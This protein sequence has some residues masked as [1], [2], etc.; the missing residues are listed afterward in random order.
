[1]HFRY[2]EWDERFR[3]NKGKD[4]FNQ[5]FDIFQQLLN[6]SSG[7]AE[8]ALQWLTELD[9]M[10]NLTKDMDD[11]D[12]GDFI[13]ELE[14][15]GYIENG[16]DDEGGSTIY[17]TRKTEKSLRQQALEDIFRDLNKGTTGEHK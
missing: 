5:L 1:M 13:Q 17:I 6:I 9:N 3:R 4:P 14:E 7:D 15:R 10:Y 16:E 8:Q 2:V 12:L 11:Y